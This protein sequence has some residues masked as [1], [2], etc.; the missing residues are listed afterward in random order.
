MSHRINRIT[1]HL[2]NITQHHT[3]PHST[4]SYR[5]KHTTRYHIISQRIK[6]II[7]YHIISYPSTSVALE[8]DGD[9]SLVAPLENERN[10]IA[11]VTIHIQPQ[12]G[13]VVCEALILQGF[14]HQL[15]VPLLRA[16]EGETL[17][18][19]DKVRSQKNILILQLR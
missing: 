18:V 3:T 5:T 19:S 15:N 12:P 13:G 6:Q 2:I 1:S 9:P 7:P 8:S 4:I 16:V 10:R 14:Q 11:P 17:H